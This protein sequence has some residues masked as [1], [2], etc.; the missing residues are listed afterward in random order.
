MGGG[1]LHPAATDVLWGFDGVV[2]QISGGDLGGY[3]GG[4][5][6]PC[7]V[8]PHLVAMTGGVWV[9]GYRWPRCSS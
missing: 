4:G 3:G 2:R 9:G 1:T 7:P 5:G 6:S 8:V